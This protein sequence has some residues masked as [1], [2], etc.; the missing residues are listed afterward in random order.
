MKKVLLSS[1][2]LLWALAHGEE[3]P[4]PVP[5]D[6]P[7]IQALPGPT[8][9][10]TNGSQ[11]DVQAAIDAAPD[12][13]TATITIPNG[14]FTWT[15]T[16]NVNKAVTLAGASA[17]G[18]TI[19]NGNAT[20]NMINVTSSANG[21]VNIYWLKVVQ[22]AN[23]NA[24][25]TYFAL[26]CD[27]TSGSNYTVLVHDCTF[28]CG[29]IFNY[30]VRINDNGIIFWNDTFIGT[31]QSVNPMGGIQFACRKYGYTSSW[32]TPS[33][34]GAQDTSGLANTYIEDCTFSDAPGGTT[35]FDA[36]SRVVLRHTLIANATVGSHGQETDPYGARQWEIYNCTFRRDA[37][38]SGPSGNPYP[39]NMNTWF[40]SRGGAGVIFNNQID[41]IPNKGELSFAVFAV[42]RGADGI[43][44]TG[45]PAARQVGQGWS[46][47]SNAAFGNPVVSNDGTG[48]ATEGI[49]IWGNTGSGPSDPKFIGLWQ[50][51]SAHN[52]CSA[53]LDI[54]PYVQSG[55]DYFTSAKPGYT[56]YVYPHPLHVAYALGG[57][58]PT[59]TPTPT[60]QPTPTP[61]PAPT[62]TPTP[63]PTPA[64]TPTPTP[65]Y[66][67]WLNE[68]SDWIRQ[69]PASPNQ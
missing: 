58:G 49:Y 54:S 42:T 38:G 66:S 60:P 1:L 25:A 40:L 47:T 11:S 7:R 61:T 36:N 48:A 3:P 35:D 32:N 17:S 68:L 52:K 63:T 15:G 45:Y 62:P 8:Y 37:S 24:S 51:D 65:S 19:Q 59:P 13:G 55:R 5:S 18:V 23:N 10:M 69:H 21:H 46:A 56:P 12:N 22:V 30:V 33:T 26:S 43:C 16:L 39:L 28:S 14:T 2:L 9:Y 31:S 20:N 50:D 27:R 41:I 44:Q 6:M 4:V 57:P 64:P 67:S 53:P 34:W 29:S